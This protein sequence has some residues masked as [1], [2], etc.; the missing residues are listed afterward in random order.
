MCIKAE[1][2]RVERTLFHAV[3]QH[4]PIKQIYSADRFSK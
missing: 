4:T 1:V 3:V 2:T